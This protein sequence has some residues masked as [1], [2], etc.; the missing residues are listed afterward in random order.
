M[1]L[2]EITTIQS[3]CN[4]MTV[5]DEANLATEEKVITPTIVANFAVSREGIDIHWVCCVGLVSSNKSSLAI[6]SESSSTSSSGKCLSSLATVDASNSH[7][8]IHRK[9]LTPIAHKETQKF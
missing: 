3:F 2:S 8:Y 4:M 1:S 5:P 9:K 7:A 6:I